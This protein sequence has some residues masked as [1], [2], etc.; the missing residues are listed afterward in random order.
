MKIAL[1]KRISLEDFT[2]LLEKDTIL[3]VSEEGK[4]NVRK[5]NEVVTK[6]VEEG[7][8]IYGVT[9]GF[10]SLYNKV[11]PKKDLKKLQENLILSHSCGVGKSLDLDIT[12]GAMLI[13]INSLAKGYSGVKLETIES[14]VKL[15]NNN[16]TPIVPEKGSLGASGDLVPSAHM[17]STLIGHGD[18]NF[19][20]YVL[21]STYILKMLNIKPL[22]LDAKEGLALINNTNFISSIAASNSY[23]SDKLAK[24]A[25]IAAALSFEAFCG[26]IDSLDLRLHNVR[27]HYFQGAVAGNIRSLIGKSEILENSIKNLQDPYSI[28]CISQ[29]HAPSKD[30]IRYISQNVEDE[31]NGIT[32]NPIIIDD[33]IISGGNFHGQYIAMS[34][35]FLSIALSNLGNV[36]QTRIAQ[37]INCNT[38]PKNLILDGGL[39]SGFMIPHYVAVALV[40]E[41]KV[42]SHPA[43]VD[44]IPVAGNQEDYVSMGMTSALKSRKI[45]EN[46][47]NIIAIELL[48]ACQALDFRKFKPGEGTKVVYDLIRESI[49][50]LK[51]DRSLHYD[52]KKVYNLI[53]SGLIYNAVKK[54]IGGII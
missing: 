19:N 52:I 20:N 1:P 17:I 32:D 22:D 25:D 3:N 54:E 8:V 5:A 29:I 36:S 41:N 21:P 35:D 51:E 16:A 43:S 45:L 28:R 7:M 40:N 31:I 12:R 33:E 27:N 11:I 9:T 49:E 15:Y 2:R 30:Y 34:M 6:A 24:I 47:E 48:T 44:S 14:L 42:F 10:G 26:N 23:Y 46:V 4:D 38:L 18:I 13:L 37:I 39:N 50:F 53:H